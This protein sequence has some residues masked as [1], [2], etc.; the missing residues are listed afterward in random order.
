MSRPLLPLLGLV[1]AGLN[2][3]VA[4]LASTDV[5][6]FYTTFVDFFLVMLMIFAVFA[7]AR[8]RLFPPRQRS[9]P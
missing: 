1:M 7:F 9:E 4:K 6:L 2:Y 3:A 5:W 8:G